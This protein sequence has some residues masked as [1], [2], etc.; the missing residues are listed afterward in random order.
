MCQRKAKQQVCVLITDLDNTLWDWFDMWYSAF[1]AMLREL[2]RVTGLPEAVLKAE[3]KTVHERHHT[4]E[5]SGLL[6]EIPIL[7]GR[8][9]K[10]FDPLVELDSVVH[11]YR[12]GRKAASRLYPD[13]KET[14]EYA[15]ERRAMTVGYTESQFY[16]TTQRV[17]ILGLDGLIDHLYSNESSVISDDNLSRMRRNDEEFYKLKHTE[18]HML[19]ITSKK[20]DAKILCEILDELRVRRADAIYVGDDLR[21]DISMANAAGITSVHAAYG[22]AHVD[23]RYE[24]LKEVTHWPAGDVKSQVT[25]TG[26]CVAP[27]FT[28][29]SFGELT[30]LFEFAPCVSD[31]EKARD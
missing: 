18:T 1:S 31:K 10:G 20:P 29:K 11:A 28:I 21:K 7:Q 12:S 8:F 25:T 6:Q 14:L 5:Y 17:R 19:P 3:I 9:G 4:S 13:I 2:V 24:L 16:Y 22:V 26:A 23:P 15:K 30:E 27:T